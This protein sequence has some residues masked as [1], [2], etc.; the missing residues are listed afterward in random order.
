MEKEKNKKDSRV[1]VIVILS[2]LVVI[3]TALCI[4]L[5]TGT[6][7]LKSKVTNNSDT[8]V[9]DDNKNEI[10]NNENVIEQSNEEYPVYEI[11]KSDKLYDWME[12][13]LKQNNIKVEVEDFVLGEG[14]KTTDITVEDLKDL[15]YYYSNYDIVK[16]YTGG[17]GL[18]DCYLL[19]VTYTDDQNRENKLTM[20]SG[21][22]IFFENLQNALNDAGVSDEQ[23][24]TMIENSVSKVNDELKDNPYVI[25]QYS[26]DFSKVK[27]E[28]ITSI[29]KRY[30]N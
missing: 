18:T 3:L 5:A 6:V 11:T 29:F 23:F 30:F 21:G 24:V 10:T 22:L 27:Y 7:N 4:L 19:R 13:I 9:T 14:S 28:S 16:T 26:F 2:I 17:K 15:F 25:I 1:I 8:D 12:Y 20:T